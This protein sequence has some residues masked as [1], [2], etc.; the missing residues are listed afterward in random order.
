METL[1]GVEQMWVVITGEGRQCYP[2]EYVA[3]YYAR[4]ARLAGA[5][6]VIVQ[7]AA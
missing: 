3:K 2:S 7:T 6:P 4:L 5:S 1:N